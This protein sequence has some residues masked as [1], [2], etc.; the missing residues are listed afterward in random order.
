MEGVVF[1]YAYVLTDGVSVKFTYANADRKNDSLPTYGA[2]DIST[3]S[4]T[5][6]QL[7]Q[8][9]LNVKF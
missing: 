7:F 1:Q 3:A 2:G 8:A 6:F 4:L 5:H 9:D